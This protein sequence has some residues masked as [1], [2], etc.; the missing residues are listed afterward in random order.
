MPQLCHECSDMLGTKKRAE[1]GV[2]VSYD[3]RDVLE[4]VNYGRR[5]QPHWVG[6]AMQRCQGTLSAILSSDDPLCG[7]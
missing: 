5:R 6:Q 2:A 7:F 4:R 3:A 1:M